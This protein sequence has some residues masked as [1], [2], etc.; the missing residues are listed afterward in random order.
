MRP[1]PRKVRTGTSFRGAGRAVVTV[2]ALVGCTSPADQPS[3][4]PSTVI[5][6][7]APLDH[8]TPVEPTTPVEKSTPVEPV[9]T[10]FDSWVVGASPLPERPDG[11]GE[12][13]PTP[14]EL[15]VR[16]LRTVD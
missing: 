2:L 13:R 14:A 10:P 9:E 5:E 15:R 4:E 3:A 7:S 6:P 8:T 16:R 11:F 12:V 1:H